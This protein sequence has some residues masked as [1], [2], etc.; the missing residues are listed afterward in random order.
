MLT[1]NYAIK[2]SH[3]IVKKKHKRLCSMKVL[4]I[5]AQNPW[6]YLIVKDLDSVYSKLSVIAMP[7]YYYSF[8]VTRYHFKVSNV[9]GSVE[10]TVNLIVQDEEG[11]NIQSLKLDLDSHSVTQDEFGEYVANSHSHN[12]NTFVLQFQV[13]YACIC[14]IVQAI[15]QTTKLILL[16]AV[17]DIRRGW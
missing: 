16:Y 15:V 14:W 6:L 8:S 17:S 4:A 5:I 3:I 7:W 13:Y 10:D 2:T 9:L 11:Q 12:N 1:L